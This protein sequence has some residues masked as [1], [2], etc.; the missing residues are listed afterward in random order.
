MSIIDAVV[1]GA[2]K[3]HCKAYL[4]G[5]HEVTLMFFDSTGKVINELVWGVKGVSRNV[6]R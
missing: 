6:G 3:G 5:R 4:L 2:R 1:A